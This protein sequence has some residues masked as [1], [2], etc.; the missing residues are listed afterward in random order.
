MVKFKS[1]V[2]FIVVFFVFFSIFS[3]LSLNAQEPAAAKESSEV[4]ISWEEFKKLLKMD[5]DEIKLSWDEFKKLLAQTGQDVKIEYNIENGMVVLTREQFKALL[6]KMKKPDVTPIV[7][8]GDYLITKAE[9]NGVMAHNS[10]TF[11]VTFD[12][13]IFKKE[14][15]NYPKIQLMPQSVALRD[16]KLDGASALVMVENGWYI[17]TTDKI[18]QHKVTLSFS[19]QTELDKGPD[20]LN[21]TIPRT[22]ITLFNIDIPVT[23][24]RV[25]IPESKYMSVTKRGIYSN[26]KAVLST[27]SNISLKLHRT[28]MKEKKKVPAKI[29]TEAMNLLSV[30]D[31]ALRVESNFKLNV[32]QNSISGV[33]LYV[34]SDYS[35]LYVR[36][37][38]YQ[39][40]RD[41]ST[42]EVE[43]REVLSVPFG[44]E[45]EGSIVFTVVAEK[46]LTGESNEIKFDGFQV[47]NSVRETGFL[48][49]EKKSAAEA[50]IIENKDIDIVDIQELPMELVN[51]ST[52]PLIL[53]LR[54]L[55]HPFS[56][57]LKVTKHEELPMVNTVID[58][59][60]VV[61][62]LLAEGKVVSRVIYTMRNTGKQ[63]LELSLPEEAEIW[64]LYVDGKREIPS[65]NK[66]GEFMIPLVRSRVEGESI[67]SF[68]VEVLYY[69]KNNSLPLVGSKKLLFPKADVVISKMLWSC[70]LPLEYHYLHFG[71][72][73]EKEDIATGIR[74]LLSGGRV[75]TYEKVRGYEQA[76]ENWEEAEQIE[77]EK[78]QKTQRMLKSNFRLSSANE[79]ADIMNQVRQEIGFAE[80]IKRERDRGVT[81]VALFK[82]EVPTS[83]KLYRFAKTV[84]EDEQL[85]LDF[86]YTR[87]WIYSLLKVLFF[88]IILIVIYRLRFRINAILIELRNWANSKKDFWMK[89][90]TPEGIKVLSILGA[91]LFFFISK[92]LFVVFVLIFLFAWLK[93]ELI[94]KETK[95]TTRK[96]RIPKRS[97]KASGE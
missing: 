87:R 19:V 94:K 46:I 45:K 29:Y 76:L 65:K 44:G 57:T 41:W 89:A 27:T 92:F 39:E 13:E 23:D 24:A 30:E 49:I 32:L 20:V 61:S 28:V 91:F 22:A 11:D 71:G 67:E 8:P 75:F 37:E 18:G 74:P 15:T 77:D 60:S 84:V 5:T 66:D 3:V 34:P 9:Y 86:Q 59:A 79:Q 16:I 21:L 93:P 36:G 56:L 51:M 31:N 68:D 12:I 73:V 17:L 40:I 2:C 62:V 81:D 10:T 55:R 69:H 83:G 85:Y 64:S 4:K 96:K 72:N 82:I 47:V 25:E 88:I 70:Y 53:G 48:G 58:N 43:N 1:L 63:F 80:N 42:K 26:V 14:R 50:E 78:I 6:Q 52:R 33:Q 38:D 35:V 90:K 7:P 97:K 54:Y 95:P